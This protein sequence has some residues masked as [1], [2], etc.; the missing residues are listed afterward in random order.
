MEM[1]DNE[2]EM[3]RKVAHIMYE[4]GRKDALAEL[5]AGL[6]I[7]KNALTIYLLK[8]NEFSNDH[9]RELFDLTDYEIEEVYDYTRSF[10]ASMLNVKATQ[11]VIETSSNIIEFPITMDM[12]EVMEETGEKKEE[13][14]IDSHS[15]DKDYSNKIID[16]L[17]PSND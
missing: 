15:S 10:V 12:G 9:I 17:L 3:I 13:Y 14:L 8:N 2:M 1:K 7:D 4:Q 6:L 5:L 11:P 16:F